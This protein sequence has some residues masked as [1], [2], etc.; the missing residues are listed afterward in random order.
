MAMVNLLFSIQGRISRGPFW[1]V[2]L[3]LLPVIS[4]LIFIIE[5]SL[6]KNPVL[7][8]V[9]LVLYGWI[10]ICVT[11]KRLHDMDAT[12]WLS[13]PVVLIP[14]AVILVGSFPG[15]VGSNQFGPDPLQRNAVR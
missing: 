12:G 11:V 5:T 13:I 2:F 4:G 15:T 7:I 14:I 3:I 6:D 10:A 1:L 8:L 9:A